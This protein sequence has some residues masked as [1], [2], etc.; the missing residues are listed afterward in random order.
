[1]KVKMIFDHSVGGVWLSGFNHCIQ[2]LGIIL[3]AKNKKE[4]KTNE[5][6]IH[7]WLVCNDLS[8]YQQ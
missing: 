3:G 8:V 4:N 2:G 7:V 5:V 6:L 1:M